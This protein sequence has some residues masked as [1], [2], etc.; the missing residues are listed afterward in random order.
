MTVLAK[1]QAQNEEFST[2]RRHIHQH[3]ETAVEEV[4]TSDFVANLLESWGVEVHRGMAKTAVIGMIKGKLGNST[5]AIGLRA[6]MDALRMREET[7]VAHCS[8][9][10][11]KM[12]ACGHDGHTAMLLA[13]AKYLAET[14]NFDGTV[15]AI[16]QPAEEGG[17]GGNVMVQEGF[18][19]KF[20]CDAVFGMHNWP[21][22]PVGT[23]AISE[24]PMTASTDSFLVKVLGKGGHAA[25][26]HKTIDPVVCGAQIVSALQHIVSRTVDPAYSAGLSV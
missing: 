3:P 16:F 25:Y 8:K 6:D 5:R 11:D 1:L 13:A 19:Q 4:K 14:R 20:P 21:W 23:F 24:G 15:Y 12:H 22:L 2:W 7:T 10:A 26:P 18:F 9:H 17:G